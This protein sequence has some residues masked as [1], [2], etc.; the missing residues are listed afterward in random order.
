MLSPLTN[1]TYRHL[2]AAQ[3]IALI[4][5]GLLTVALGLLAYDLAGAD[6]GAV[7]GTALAI[8]MVAYVGVAPVVGAFAG[9]AAPAGLPGRHGPRAGRHRPVAAV[10]DG[11]LAGLRPDLRA[12]VRLRRVHADFPGD[13][14]R[15]TA[16]RGGI[17]QGALAGAARLRSGKPRQ[18]GAGGGLAGGHRLPRPVRGNGRGIPRVGPAG[19]FRGAARSGEPG[20]AGRRGLRQDHARHP[21]LPEDAAPARPAG[22][23]RRGRRRRSDG[24][25][26]YGRDRAGA[27]WAGPTPMSRSCWRPMAPGRWRWR[28]CC[29]ACWSGRPTA[30]SCWRAPGCW[31]RGRS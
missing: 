2:F 5:T 27:C 13:H 19:R 12:P 9:P 21:D 23:Q 18:P 10:R 20:G 28:S 17:Y 4:G 3:V 16:G 15:R 31:R 22:A 1:R 25:R 26:Q 8:K 29:R 11:G 24:H 6:A 14:S 30:P 7:L